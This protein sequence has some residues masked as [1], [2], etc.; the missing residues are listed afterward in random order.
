MVVAVVVCLQCTKRLPNRSWWPSLFLLM[1]LQAEFLR[2]Y[3][4]QTRRALHEAE[5]LLEAEQHDIAQEL[6]RTKLE[7]EKRKAARKARSEE[8]AEGAKAKS[9]RNRGSEEKTEVAAESDQIHKKKAKRETKSKKVDVAVAIASPPT[10]QAPPPPADG[11]CRPS[12]SPSRAEPETC[13]ASAP[14][15]E[16]E[17][18]P[19]PPPIT[20]P[21]SCLAP[22]PMSQ[23][24]SCPAQPPPLLKPAPPPLLLRPAK[25]Q[26]KHKAMKA[27]LKV[28]VTHRSKPVWTAELR[29]LSQ[30]TP[31]PSVNWKGMLRNDERQVLHFWRELAFMDKEDRVG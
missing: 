30:S 4:E 16:L 10:R 29:A 26:C 1:D 18:C 25:P 28:G 19:A 8:K 22:P 20:Q 12:P 24:E 21:E 13:L 31:L 7:M 2:Q 3:A 27:A 11:L 15:A 14:I 23:V 9:K 5:A 6:L 17:T